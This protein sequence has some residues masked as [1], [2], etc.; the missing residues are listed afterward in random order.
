MTHVL[1][2]LGEKERSKNEV[3]KLIGSG[4]KTKRRKRLASKNF[5]T[6]I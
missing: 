5:A 6:M 3:L 2:F 4:G 1:G